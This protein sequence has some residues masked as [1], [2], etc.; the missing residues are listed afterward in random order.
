[1]I[2]NMPKDVRSCQCTYRGIL[3]KKSPRLTIISASLSI[4]I[5][6]VYLQVS[7]P[8]SLILMTLFGIGILF[9]IL[10]NRFY[11]L[12]LLATWGPPLPLIKYLN[13]REVVVPALFFSV[14]LIWFVR[15]DN[16][17][18][19]KIPLVVYIFFL[20]GFIHYLKSPALPGRFFDP[21]APYGIFRIYW[22]FFSQLLIY[23]MVLYFFEAEQK[24]IV[25]VKFLTILSSIVILFYILLI[26]WQPVTVPLERLGFSWDIHYLETI[27]KFPVRAG[28]LSVFGLLLFQIVLVF[29]R[30]NFRGAWPSFLTVLSI[31]ALILSG[32]RTAFIAAFTSFILYLV[33]MRK[34]RMLVAVILA[35][36]VLVGFFEVSPKLIERCP[37]QLQRFL[38]VLSP[39]KHQSHFGLERIPGSLWRLNLWQLGWSQVKEHPIIGNGYKSVTKQ[40]VAIT[41][42]AEAE[43]EHEM[44]VKGGTLHNAYLSILMSFGLLGLFVFLAIVFSHMYKI[45]RL[46]TIRRECFAKRFDLWLI[47]AIAAILVS[48]WFE[49]STISP[50][51]FFFLALINTRNCRLK[52]SKGK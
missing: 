50:K 40:E 38:I 44:H 29:G 37:N 24:Q 2:T 21:D 33:L 22:E 32:G 17:A 43:Y 15:K 45:Y 47:I 31:L 20:L 8:Q 7:F 12:L 25:L 30:T 48:F 13:F 52:I 14:I 34:Y 1:M 26:F 46:F 3:Y 6:F 5:A 51:L 39:M 19:E 35:I 42:R 28:P 23:C 4:A 16:L 41:S 11:W 27:G 10:P 36:M 49:G 18:F 9:F